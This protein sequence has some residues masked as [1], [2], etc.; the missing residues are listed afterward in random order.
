M[1]V[2]R[3]DFLKSGAI[4]GAALLTGCNGQNDGQRSGAYAFTMDIRDGYA[5]LFDRTGKNLVVGAISAHGKPHPIV[6]RIDRGRVVGTP[7]VKSV[8]TNAWDFSGWH[9]ELDLGSGA[10]ALTTPEERWPDPMKCPT[11]DEW[12][13]LAW[14][15]P[16]SKIYPG[17]TLAQDWPKKLS[18]RLAI[19]QGSLSVGESDGPGVFQFKD[20]KTGEKVWEQ[21]LSDVTTLTQQISGGNVVFKFFPLGDGLPRGGQPEHVMEIASDEGVMLKITNGLPPEKPYEIGQAIAH[22]GR[23]RDL[24]DVSG[25]KNVLPYFY[26]CGTGQGSCPGDFCPY[27][28]FEI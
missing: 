6:L 16:A 28:R 14:L 10:S 11:G 17:A 22:F 2:Y 23:Y 12:N 20:E 21:A 5:Y 25:D 15:P 4:G 19:A 1:R 8:G 3:R 13:N 9:V 7:K 27:A 26:P 18:S 24:L